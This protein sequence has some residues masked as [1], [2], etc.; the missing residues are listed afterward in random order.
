[1]W[2]LGRA[3]YGLKEAPK[4]WF[5]E[6]EQYLRNIHGMS[7]YPDVT[8]LF[9]KIQKG[10]IFFVLVYVDDL[11]LI[12][13]S[14]SQ[15]NVFKALITR[16]FQCKDLGQASVYLGLQIVRDRPNRRLWVGQP[17]Y[18]ASLLKKFDITRDGPVTSPLPAGWSPVLEGEMEEVDK[19][20]SQAQIPASAPYWRKTMSSCIKAW[21]V[22]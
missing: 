18:I 21:L 5:E 1:V 12:S 19:N 9:W 20:G 11:L 15:I 22:H 2:K 10:H 17:R 14:R 3:L 7:T 13:S 4:C 8:N 16:T 6:L